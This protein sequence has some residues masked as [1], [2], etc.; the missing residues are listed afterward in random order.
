[1]AK[2]PIQKRIEKLLERDGPWCHVCGFEIREFSQATQTPYTASCDHIAP[3]ANGGTNDLENLKLAHKM[4]NA[5]RAKGTIASTLAQDKYVPHIVNMKSMGYRL[6]RQRFL[7]TF[8]I[9]LWKF[10]LDWQFGV[11]EALK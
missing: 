11:E 8:K 1:M 6:K 7:G 9:R 5:L 2:S 4:C 3:K 10:N